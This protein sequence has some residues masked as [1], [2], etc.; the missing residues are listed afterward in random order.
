MEKARQ[1]VCPQEGVGVETQ[2][3][4]ASL[5]VYNLMVRHEY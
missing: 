5:I 1:H 4:P 2:D 3:I